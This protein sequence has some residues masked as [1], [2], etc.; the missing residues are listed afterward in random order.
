MD[1]C[2]C[3]TLFD[4]AV[5]GWRRP[6]RWMQTLL[7]QAPLAPLEKKGAV[8]A[9]ALG[10]AAGGNGFWVGS[11]LL[12]MHVWERVVREIVRQVYHIYTIL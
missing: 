10:S 9:G 2:D 4:A 12:P 3:G 11:D 8:P 1:K 5:V 7:R 6:C